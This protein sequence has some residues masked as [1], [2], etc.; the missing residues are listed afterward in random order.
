MDEKMEN[1]IYLVRNGVPRSNEKVGS[2]GQVRG[3]GHV[4]RNGAERVQAAKQTENMN[5]IHEIEAE[6][7]LKGQEVV[8]DRIASGKLLRRD[9]LTQNVCQTIDKDLEEQLEW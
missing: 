3:A 5:S 7:N 6:G 4:Q 2:T 9:Y 8:K 1:L